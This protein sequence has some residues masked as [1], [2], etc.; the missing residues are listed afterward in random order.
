MTTVTKVTDIDTDKPDGAAIQVLDL[1]DYQRETRL[2]LKNTWGIEHDVATSANDGKHKFVIDSSEPSD[3]PNGHIYFDD[4]GT[5]KAKRLRIKESGTYV[6]ADQSIPENS[7]MLFYQDTL[8]VGWANA[9][10]SLDD[11]ALKVVQPGGG[12]GAISGTNVFSSVL[13]SLHATVIQDESTHTHTGTTVAS[14]ATANL[15]GAGSTPWVNNTHTHTFTSN[16]GLAHN[17][18]LTMAIKYAT[19]IIAKKTAI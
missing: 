9:S 7:V 17:H 10:A 6:D 2:S 3:T 16:A 12:G 4:T 19:L 5:T 8:P 13:E 1:D 18:D 15:N 14:G 11:L